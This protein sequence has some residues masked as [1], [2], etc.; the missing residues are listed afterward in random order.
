MG[1]ILLRGIARVVATRQIDLA[2]AVFTCLPRPSLAARATR[3]ARTRD[4]QTRVAVDLLA[5]C[6][7]QTGHKS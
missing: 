4:R 6:T 2:V 5:K 7:R 3:G 1:R